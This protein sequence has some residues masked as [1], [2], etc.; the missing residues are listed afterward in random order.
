MGDETLFIEPVLQKL[1]S[2]SGGEHKVI[3]QKRSSDKT[4]RATRGVPK[5]CQ[6]IQGEQL[7]G[8]V[9]LFLTGNGI[10]LF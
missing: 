2:F 6:I 3:R 4:S 1:E 5:D 9:F 8:M 7:F 10:L